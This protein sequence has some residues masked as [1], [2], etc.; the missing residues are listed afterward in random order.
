MIVR[1]LP[2]GRIN[3]DTGAFQV[4]NEVEFACKSSGDCCRMN[5]IPVT[6]GEIEAIQEHG[7]ELDQ[8]LVSLSP[9]VI[10]GKTDGARIKSYILKK[11]P[12]SRECVF[13][14]E[15]N[16]CKIHEYKPFACRMYPFS[17]EVIDKNQ[18]EIRVH[19]QSVCRNVQAGMTKNGNSMQIMKGIFSLLKDKFLSE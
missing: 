9:V 19:V 14:D 16:R 5:E 3:L 15:H 13:L 2:V 10:P 4:L 12:F 6:E 8:F 11:K 17:Y 1:D 18:I 7:W